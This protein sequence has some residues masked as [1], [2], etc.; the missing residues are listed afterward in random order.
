MATRAWRR[1]A[2]ALAAAWERERGAEVRD[3]SRPGPARAAVEM[4]A[5]EWRQ[6][7]H[8]GDRY[9]LYVASDCA[10]PAPTLLRIRNP[11]AKLLAGRRETEAWAIPAARLRAAAERG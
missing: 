10:T 4:T 1:M 5:N 6:A 8:L 11:F 2:V 7:C 3:V 9:W